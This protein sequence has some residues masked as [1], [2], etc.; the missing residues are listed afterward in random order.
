MDHNFIRVFYG[1]FLWN[2]FQI[3]FVM[4]V[5]SVIVNE[6][7]LVNLIKGSSSFTVSSILVYLFISIVYVRN[8]LISIREWSEKSSFEILHIKRTNIFEVPFAIQNLFLPNYIVKVREDR[9]EKFFLITFELYA[10]VIKDQGV[11]LLKS[12]GSDSIDS[13]D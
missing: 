5:Y 10:P 6:I 13:S 4:V 1:M 3:S 8:T 12:K 2:F 7:D 9:A 11:C